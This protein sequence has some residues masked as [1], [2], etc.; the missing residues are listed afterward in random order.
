MPLLSPPPKFHVSKADGTPAEAWELFTYINGTST[1]KATYQDFGLGSPNTNPVVLDAR[2]EATLFLSGSYKFVLKDDVGATIWT[3]DEIRD[4][5]TDQTFTNAI[6]SGTLTINSTSVSWA[7]NPTHS[8][9]H[10]FTGNVTIN[11]NTAIGNIAA[12]SLTI[13]SDTITWTNGATHS[14]NHAFSGDVA[15]SGA[16]SNAHGAITDTFYTPT[17]TSVANVTTTTSAVCY[18]GRNGSFVTVSGAIS[19]DPTSAATYTQVGIS[20]PIASN[21]TGNDCNGLAASLQG[22]GT[23]VL[24]GYI[25]ADITNDRAQ[26]EFVTGA[27]VASRGWTFEF[28]YP[29]H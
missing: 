4:L 1:P 19:V 18:Y 10:T 26:L 8:G 9:N 12:D 14:G 2:G 29:I 28:H 25:V 15:V 6:F 21:L 23:S 20:L 13:A 16:L 3:V 11:G 7:G 24:S 22:P 27:D 17:L 5:T